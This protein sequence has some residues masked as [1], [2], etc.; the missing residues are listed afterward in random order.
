MILLTPKISFPEGPSGAS[1]DESE[2]SSSS[3]SSEDEGVAKSKQEGAHKGNEN[4]D[5][6]DDAEIR[7]QVT[8]LIYS[9]EL[10]SLCI[11]YF[12]S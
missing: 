6:E 12:I 1:D 7:S 3:S 5:D 9:P 8:D 2:S 10:I 11:V 4:E